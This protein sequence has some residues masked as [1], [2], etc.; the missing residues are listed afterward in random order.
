MKSSKEP[1]KNKIPMTL[2]K[3]WLGSTLPE[4]YLKK[5]IADRNL[6]PDTF[7]VNLWIDKTTLSSEKNFKAMKRFYKNYGIQL[8]DVSELGN[9]TNQSFFKDELKHGKEHGSTTAN[10]GFVSAADILRYAI[11]E[12]EGGV[13]LDADDQLDDS[14]FGEFNRA[15][16]SPQTSYFFILDKYRASNNFIMAAPQADFITTLNQKINHKYMKLYANPLLKRAYKSEQGDLEGSI[17]QLTGPEFLYRQMYKTE[18]NDQEVKPFDTVP[19]EESKPFDVI[20]EEKPKPF[21]GIYEGIHPVYGRREYPF[22]EETAYR[23]EQLFYLIF[24]FLKMNGLNDLYKYLYKGKKSEYSYFNEEKSDYKTIKIITKFQ[25]IID[26]SGH[27]TLINLFGS[28][29]LDILSKE[30]IVLLQEKILDTVPLI[31]S[32][33]KPLL[34]IPDSTSSVTKTLTANHTLKPVKMV[35]SPSSPIW[36]TL[37]TSVNKYIQSRHDTVTTAFF[38]ND[39]LTAAKVGLAKSLL[40]RIQTYHTMGATKVELQALIKQYQRLNAALEELAK[41]TT[42]TYAIFDANILTYTNKDKMISSIEAPKL[43]LN[44]LGREVNYESRA[45]DV[46]KLAQQFESQLKHLA[47]PTRKKPVQ[48]ENAI[49]KS[50]LNRCLNHCLQEANTIMQPEI[51]LLS[52]TRRFS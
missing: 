30:S 25:N 21:A 14:F 12:K 43:L 8:R 33:D 39:E 38:R 45:L 10:A 9:F 7:Q 6:L 26:Q 37:I 17:Y 42:E 11:L 34:Q 22:D 44:Y 24:A 49:F 35:I 32:Q 48:K 1:S 23:R 36:N 50:G 46:E 47:D 29:N 31:D 28:A 40:Y 52:V 4:K 18:Q 15:H 27:P 13:Y 20:P 5:L 3:I 19:G 51:N 2:H 41:P 16:Q